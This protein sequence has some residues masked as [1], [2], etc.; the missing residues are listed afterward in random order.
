[1]PAFKVHVLPAEVVGKARK[2]DEGNSAGF[3]PLSRVV[4]VGAT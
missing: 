3:S 4:E 1:M 2:R